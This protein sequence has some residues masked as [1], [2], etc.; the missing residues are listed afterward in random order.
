MN[1]KLLRI[2]STNAA[3]PLVRV[4][5]TKEVCGSA[6]WEQTGMWCVSVISCLPHPSFFHRDR[7]F[8]EKTSVLSSFF[9]KLNV[10]I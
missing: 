6:Q 5:D 7:S 3:W 2:F 1:I 9:S 10:M 8:G 4:W